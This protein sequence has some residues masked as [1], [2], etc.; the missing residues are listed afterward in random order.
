MS[1]GI[2]PGI[3]EDVLGSNGYA[4]DDEAVWH[5]NGSGFFAHVSHLY[6]CPGYE[7]RRL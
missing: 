1:Y 2:D 7:A 3:F 4:R 5:L 6:L